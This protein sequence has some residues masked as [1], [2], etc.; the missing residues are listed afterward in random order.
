LNDGDLL[1]ASS[2]HPTT[3][4]SPGLVSS[5]L[6]LAEPLAVLQQIIKVS[7]VSIHTWVKCA[8]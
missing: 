6:F 2:L 4:G 1:E 7:G 3:E 5:Y 8:Q